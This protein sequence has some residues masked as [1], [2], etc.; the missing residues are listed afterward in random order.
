M[1][2]SCS[3]YFILEGDGWSFKK[4]QLFGNKLNGQR[5]TV[6][7]PNLAATNFDIVWKKDSSLQAF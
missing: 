5:K 7:I 2:M 3:T 6:F 1:V 4:W